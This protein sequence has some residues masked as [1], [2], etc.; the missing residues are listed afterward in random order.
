MTITAQHLHTW[1][2]AE[3]LDPAGEKLGKLDDIHYCASEPLVVAIS[4]GL[5]GRKHHVASLRGAAVNRDAVQLGLAAE[6]LVEAD[7][8]GIGRDELA[9]LAAHDERLGALEPEDLEGWS[10]REERLAAEARARA[11]ADELDDEAARR[12]EEEAQARA[13]ARDAGE[14]A[15]EARH[16]REEAEERAAQARR[17]AVGGR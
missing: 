9:A 3:V 11:A 4:S 1:I 2:G 15:E 13:R 5:A 14:E 8:H 10:A 16:A 17:D 7:G 6:T 12:A